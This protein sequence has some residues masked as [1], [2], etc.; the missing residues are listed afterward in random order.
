MQYKA[1]SGGV[2]FTGGASIAVDANHAATCYVKTTSSG[3]MVDDVW[4]DVYALYRKRTVKTVTVAEGLA[5]TGVTTGQR[6]APGEELTIGVS[7]VAE[8]YEPSVTITKN[9]DSSVLLTTN[10]VSFAYTMPDFDI[11]VSVT[12]NEVVAQLPAWATDVD[13]QSV[14]DQAVSDKYADW[15]DK[16]A[17]GDTTVDRS[18]Q[19][20]MNV[21]VAA[22]VALTID[23]IEVT[24]DG[25]IVTIGATK[26][27][28]G[29]TDAIELG[30][31]D[32]GEDTSSINGILN[33]MVADTLGNWAKKSIPLNNLSYVGG[34]AQVLIPAG[35]GRFVKASVDY[36]KPS[37]SITAVTE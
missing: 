17:D 8:G 28:S 16:V 20:L 26:T 2:E 35:D 32:A 34:K 18:A 23:G 12:A 6:V 27:I 14:I 15:A 5:V 33:V 31:T 11:D 13:G 37:S 21:P 22:A 1:N 19:F 9:S 36:S 4:C 25:T 24:S 3:G 7:G 30:T 10:A 29:T